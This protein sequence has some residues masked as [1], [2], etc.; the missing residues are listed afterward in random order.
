MTGLSWNLLA[1]PNERITRISSNKWYV[2]LWVSQRQAGGK[3]GAV[4]KF[5]LNCKTLNRSA[6][7]NCPTCNEAPKEVDGFLAYASQLNAAQGGYKAEFYDE[8]AHLEETHFWFSVRCRLIVWAFRK[9]AS[10]LSSFFEIG[11]GTGFV[12]KALNQAFPNVRLEGSEMLTSGLHYAA[13]RLPES[14]FIQMD[15]RNIPYADEF[16]AIGAFDVLEHI[17][18]DD[19]VLKQAHNA[20]KLNGVLFITVPQHK[21]LWSSIDDYSCHVRRYS[22]KELHLKIE[23]AGFRILRSTSFVSILMPIMALSRASKR[24]FISETDP[25][26]E[27]KISRL[28]NRL[29]S[30][31]MSVESSLIRAGVNFPFGG[32]RLVVARKQRVAFNENQL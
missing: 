25:L 27:L 1:F 13:E 2:H 7:Q 9:Y 21:W 15:A 23:A 14:T 31:L 19:I 16:D 22:A 3:R 18:E 5:C 20:L 8:Y 29:L 4:M 30:A 28:M 26:A 32:S 24:G 10:N 11:C 6:E 12:L 17:E